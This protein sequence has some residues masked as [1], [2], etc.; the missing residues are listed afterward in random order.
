MTVAWNFVT[1]KKYM[2][3]FFLRE[4]VYF[5]YM[6]SGFSPRLAGSVAPGLCETAHQDGWTFIAK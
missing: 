3:F 5:W 4:W 2:I 1:W 6:A